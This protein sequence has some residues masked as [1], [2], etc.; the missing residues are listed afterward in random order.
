M[1]FA[2]LAVFPDGGRR[3]VGARRIDRDTAINSNRVD[4]DN[5]PTLTNKRHAPPM[6]GAALSAP[7][8]QDTRTRV[9]PCMQARSGR[10]HPAHMP[11]IERYNEPVIVFLTVCSQD[12]KKILAH[13]DA[14]EA[15]VKSWL[16]A[17]TW[18]VGRYVIMPD[19]VHLFCAPAVFPSRSLKQWVKFWKANASL[20]WPRENEHPI[21]ERDFWDTQLR[22]HESYDEKWDYVVENP[23]RAGLVKRSEDW[24]FQGELSFLPWY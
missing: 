22:R 13:A 21:W 6:E 17:T 12:R 20:G 5:A 15:I 9:P 2:P 14:A 11:P 19:H 3:V 8:G 18:S 24:P 10:K 7:I 1:I 4:D 16:E 23:V